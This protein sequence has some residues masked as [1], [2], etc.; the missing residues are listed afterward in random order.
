M[1]LS[2]AALRFLALSALRLRAKKKAPKPI[3]A[4]ARTEQ[5]TASPMTAAEG[6]LPDDEPGAEMAEAMVSLVEPVELTGA[7][8]EPEGPALSPDEVEVPTAY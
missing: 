7:E 4:A 1:A 2:N 5:P 6:W 3:K 8:M